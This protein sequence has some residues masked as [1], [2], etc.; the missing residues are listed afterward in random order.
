MVASYES[1]SR[2]PK[3]FLFQDN[4]GMREKTELE[5]ESMR[6]VLLDLG[7]EGQIPFIFTEHYGNSK[8]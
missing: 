5:G 4:E 8:G 1:E 7:G 3:A 6:A 2:G